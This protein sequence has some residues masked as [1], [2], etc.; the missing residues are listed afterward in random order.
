MLAAMERLSRNELLP[1][2]DFCPE[3]NLPSGSGKFFAFKHIPI[4]AYCWYSKRFP[5]VMYISHYTYKNTQ[6]LHKSDTERVHANY[7]R[8]EV[9]GHDE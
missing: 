7:N 9:D 6:K 8:I 5:S 4:R 2:S 1:A 3:G